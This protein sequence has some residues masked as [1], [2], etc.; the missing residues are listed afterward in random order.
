MV[1]QGPLHRTQSRVW[2]AEC[3]GAWFSW[4]NPISFR[5]DSRNRAVW[6]LGSSA[7]TFMSPA[8]M[9]LLLSGEMV[10]TKSSSCSWKLEWA[11]GGG[12]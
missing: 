1:A 4:E 2:P 7:Q 5:A 9:M 10:F 11:R 3:V 12:R 8:M 6:S